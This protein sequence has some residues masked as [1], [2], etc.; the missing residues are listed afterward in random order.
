MLALGA[1]LVVSP[2]G[3]AL[4]QWHSE[5]QARSASGLATTLAAT[6]TCAEWVAA[7]DDDRRG[8]ARREALRRGWEARLA[9]QQVSKRLDGFCAT[10]PAEP[11]RAF[12][13]E[14]MTLE[15]VS[16]APGA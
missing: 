7:G 8:W 10:R 12:E 5:G 16:D 13:A 6:S 14:Q 4:W 9:S 1:W 11:L 15:P 3:W 2:V